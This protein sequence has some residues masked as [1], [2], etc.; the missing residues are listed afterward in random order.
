ME[1]GQ[2][3]IDGAKPIARRNEDRGIAGE[4]F[5]GAVLGRGALQQP[6]RGGAD[7]DDPSAFGARRVQRIGG[8]A[9]DRAPL[10]MHLVRGR[11]LGLD[12]QER[13]RPHMQRDPVNAD[14]ALAQRRLERRRKMQ[15]G[16]GCRD[17]AFIDGEHGLIVGSVA[18][19]GRALR[20]DV[21]RQRRRAEVGDGLI[22]RR[23]VK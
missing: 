19:I 10:R 7:R 3:D 6:Q 4:W 15:A 17:R 16:G 21:R 1:I 23:P 12:R 9:R 14:A 5:D 13:P 20:G 18:L 22:Q 11:V 2:Q 8:F